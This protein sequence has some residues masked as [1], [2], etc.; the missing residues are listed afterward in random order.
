MENNEKWSS[1]N[2]FVA[3]TKILMGDG[4]EKN[5]E[6]VVGTDMVMSYNLSL[7]LNEPRE[8]IA[9]KKTTQYLFIT[10]F[11]ENGR[12]ITCTH[13][14]PFYTENYEIGSYSPERT[15]QFINDYYYTTLTPPILKISIG[16]FLLDDLGNKIQ[17]TNITETNGVMMGT[18]LFTVDTN[19]NF[20]AN[21]IL[22]HN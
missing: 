12:E 20:Y 10:Y 8:V 16:D 2:C 17:I 7:Q 22:V 18:H 19:N 13:D 14:H 1:T 3:G 4:T 9:T 21:S 11:L 6:D 5:I 15:V